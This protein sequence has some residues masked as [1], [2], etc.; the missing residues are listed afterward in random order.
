MRAFLF[1]NENGQG[2]PPCVADVTAFAFLKAREKEQKVALCTALRKSRWNI[3][4]YNDVIRRATPLGKASFSE[5]VITR[6]VFSHA[7]LIDLKAAYEYA[8]CFL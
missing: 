3:F 6:N 4:A 7:I 1:A 5:N 2:V 8:N